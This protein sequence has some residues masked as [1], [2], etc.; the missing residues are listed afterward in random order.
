MRN[1]LTNIGAAV[2][3]MS[4]TINSMEFVESDKLDEN[5]QNITTTI[6]KITTT[7]NKLL[8]SKSNQALGF[9][10]KQTAQYANI[11]ANTDKLVNKVNGLDIAKMNALAKM[12]GNAAAFSQSIN[13]NFDRLAS[14]INEKIAPL[15]EG[16]KTAIENADKTIKDRVTNKPQTSNMLPNSTQTNTPTTSILQPT[17]SNKN[18][19]V[20]QGPSQPKLQQNR[21]LLELAKKQGIEKCIEQYGNGFAINV[22]MVGR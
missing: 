20:T 11:V 21:K 5:L 1:M 17:N 8:G 2:N 6:T 12:F 4:S 9:L 22:R 18:K 19:P 14:I 15:I 13:G 7:F 10:V 16:L 3:S